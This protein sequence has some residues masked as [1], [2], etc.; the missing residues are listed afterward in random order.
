[1]FLRD[2]N[3]YFTAIILLLWY[4][5]EDV[6]MKKILVPTDFSKQAEYALDAAIQIAETMDAT[7]I[8]LHVVENPAA[9]SFQITGEMVYYD[10]STDEFLLNVKKRATESLAQ[11]VNER[12]EAKSKIEKEV[13]VGLPFIHFSELIAER[14]VDLV[15]MGSK[16]T[17]TFVDMIVGSN[18]EKMVRYAKCPVITVKSE[19]DITKVQNILYATNFKEKEDMVLGRI[20]ILQDYLNA[21]LNLLWVHTPHVLISEEEISEKLNGLVSKHNLKNYVV[22]VKRSVF[23]DKGILEYAANRGIDMIA[24][25]THGRRG[26]AHLFTGSI[27]EEVVNEGPQ[28]IWTFSMHD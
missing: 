19:F 15:V 12:P 17:N 21:S 23:V 9:S 16:G 10:H 7:I 4:R 14:N 24:M 11:M 2:C 26:L 5:I 3:H 1:M 6:P 18:T 28:P 8:L 20:S 27:A 22:S 25:S 13:L